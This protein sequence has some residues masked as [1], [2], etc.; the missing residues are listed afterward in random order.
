[1]TRHYKL[2]TGSNTGS[3]AGGAGNDRKGRSSLC[4]RYGTDW[5]LNGKE[6][7]PQKASP[8]NSFCEV[9]PTVEKLKPLAEVVC[10]SPMNAL[11]PPLSPTPPATSSAPPTQA[12]SPRST[13]RRL[14]ARLSDWTS[15]DVSAWA[16]STTLA[17]EVV[18]C[19]RDNAI[20]GNVLESL[21]ETDLR[22]MGVHKLCFWLALRCQRSDLLRSLNGGQPASSFC[23]TDAPASAICQPSMET[24]AKTLSRPQSAAGSITIHERALPSPTRGVL[25]RTHSGSSQTMGR[26][27]ADLPTPSR[28]FAFSAR[29]VSLTRAST[30]VK[31]TV[32][33]SQCLRPLPQK[34]TFC[35][36]GGSIVKQP[37][38]S[39]SAIKVR[40][41]EPV[42]AT[43]R[44][45]SCIR[46]R[47]EYH[48]PV[49]VSAMP[50]VSS[51]ACSTPMASVV[52]RPT[53]Q[54][55]GWEVT[56]RPLS[57]SRVVSTETSSCSSGR[58]R[59]APPCRRVRSTDRLER[60]RQEATPGPKTSAG[61]CDEVEP[62]SEANDGSIFREVCK[63]WEHIASEMAKNDEENCKNTQRE[64][65]SLFSFDKVD[66]FA[67]RAS[68]LLD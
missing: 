68:E 26:L 8:D 11:T 39:A 32:C 36:P 54:Q 63:S 45:S 25:Q 62:G 48:A 42:N 41:L 19:L 50:V 58:V 66:E 18:A 46:T 56:I 37:V 23:P 59:Q 30:P 24:P 44:S 28:A 49:T 5:T 60:E 20:T 55:M 3:V 57:P 27:F 64:L 12:L 31:A 53:T 47:I 33:T 22:S 29:S 61:Y 4:E 38:R 21:S 34:P 51:V 67:R 15:A 9:S 13:L 6:N 65:E 43:P 40:T 52:A 16:S 7:T 1:M 35:P 14:P 10:L 2:S 17:P